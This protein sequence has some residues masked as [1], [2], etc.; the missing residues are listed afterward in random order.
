[1]AGSDVLQP[2]FPLYRCELQWPTS[3]REA[4]GVGENS[5]RAD[6]IGHRENSPF[7]YTRRSA[8]V[9]PM[10]SDAT[11]L[12]SADAVSGVIHGRC[13]VFKHPLLCAGSIL[14]VPAPGADPHRRLQ[15]QQLLDGPV[16][17][18]AGPA[19]VFRTYTPMRAPHR[20]RWWERVGE[21]AGHCGCASLF[22]FCKYAFCY[23]RG[24][25]QSSSCTAGIEKFSG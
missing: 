6:L 13:V 17:I 15:K 22:F 2:R 9:R 12:T 7:S 10:I 8:T 18:C 5:R 4:S 16:A 20:R 1:V 24:N 3:C 11:M 25:Y 23:F 21:Q 14:V 19:S